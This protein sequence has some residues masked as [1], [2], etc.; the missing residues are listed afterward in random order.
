[1]GSVPDVGVSGTGWTGALPA[2]EAPAPAPA[3]AASYGWAAEQLQQGAPAVEEAPEEAVPS[4]RP[5]A[6][7]TAPAPSRKLLRQ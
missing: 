5:A 3:A 7:A 2:V 6:A 4:P 1:M